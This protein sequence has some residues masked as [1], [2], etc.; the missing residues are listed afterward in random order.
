M[1]VTSHTSR[2][3]DCIDDAP[4][5]DCGDRVPI[6]FIAL[7]NKCSLPFGM[8]TDDYMS[9]LRRMA[10]TVPRISNSEGL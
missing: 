6:E 2:A 5:R 3:A 1:S 9:R 10:R 8:T 7:A 4:V